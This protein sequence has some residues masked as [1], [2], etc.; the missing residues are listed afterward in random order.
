MKNYKNLEKIIIDRL[1]HLKSKLS[2]LKHP[3][4]TKIVCYNEITKLEN[5]I[6]ELE[7]LQKQ[8]GI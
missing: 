8:M 6:E 1:N 7:Y 5:K 3:K 2:D 4:L